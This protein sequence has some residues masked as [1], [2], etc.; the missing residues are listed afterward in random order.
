MI[1]DVSINSILDKVLEDVGCTESRASKMDV[2]DLLKYALGVCEVI[3]ANFV[4]DCWLH[5]MKL[6][7]IF[8]RRL[9][10]PLGFVVCYDWKLLKHAQRLL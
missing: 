2:D 4:L 7:S 10:I 1:D 6:E 8:P 5:F 9:R 3:S